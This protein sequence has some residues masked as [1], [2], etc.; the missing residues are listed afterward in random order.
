MSNQ[1]GMNVSEI[2]PRWELLSQF[3]EQPLAQVPGARACL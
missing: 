2:R 1:A 3:R